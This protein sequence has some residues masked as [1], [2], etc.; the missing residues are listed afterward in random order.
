MSLDF[1]L[2]EVFNYA[3]NCFRGKFFLGGTAT[4]CSLK[5]CGAAPAPSCA[6]DD[7]DWCRLTAV[8]V[9]FLT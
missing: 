4:H 7:L 6:P 8:P 5:E 9:T 2:F 1:T 3:P